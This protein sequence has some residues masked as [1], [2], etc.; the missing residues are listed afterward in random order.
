MLTSD[1]NSGLN[2]MGLQGVNIQFSMLSPS[3]PS[4]GVLIRE[5]YRVFG[6]TGEGPPDDLDLAV[7]E[8]MFPVEEGDRLD[9]QR[10]LADDQLRRI[11]RECRQT[12]DDLLTSMSGDALLAELSDGPRLTKAQFDR[13]TA[14]SLWYSLVSSLDRRDP[15]GLPVPAPGLSGLEIPFKARFQMTVV[16]SL[17]LKLDITLVFI[18]E[19]DLAKLAAEAARARKPISG[20]LQRLLRS[21]FVRHI[22]NSLAHGTFEQVIVGIRFSDEDKIVTATPGFLD[23]LSTCL[24]LAQLQAAAAGVRR[25]GH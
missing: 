15:G 19:G 14:G 21:D 20:R 18:R 16:G 23:Y 7:F 6:M 11:H 9:L 12:L 3:C 22:R 13:L 17:V 1:P 25:V 4:A 5:L 8:S 10:S 2:S 24:S